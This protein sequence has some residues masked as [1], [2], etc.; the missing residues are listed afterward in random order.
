MPVAV[1][2]VT[3]TSKGFYEP[4]KAA[5]VEVL[6]LRPSWEFDEIA[7]VM[8]G[9]YEVLDTAQ[10]HNALR[11]KVAALGA[12]AVIMADEGVYVIEEVPYRWMAGVAIRRK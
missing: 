2:D 6:K 12:T 8:V 3:K 10:M 1:L 7:T 11:T 9:N 5:D 4:T